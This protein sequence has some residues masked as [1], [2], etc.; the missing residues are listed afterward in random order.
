MK[1]LICDVSVAK[2]DTVKMS[3]ERN[4]IPV[5]FE[6][7]VCALQ[8]QLNAMV[9]QEQK[10]MYTSDLVESKI[11][12]L[13]MVL[14][15]NDEVSHFRKE[16]SKLEKKRDELTAENNV[17]HALGTENSKLNTSTG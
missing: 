6:K 13:Q 15:L 17:V 5:C 16:L 14:S 1:S 2:V 3:G 12:E 8:T 9:E 11:S 10:L 4:L 7:H